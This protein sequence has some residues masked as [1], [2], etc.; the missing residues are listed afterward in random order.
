[1]TWKKRYRLDRKE[2]ARLVDFFEKMVPSLSTYAE[3]RGTSAQQLVTSVHNL[4]R[5]AEELGKDGL[6]QL[7]SAYAGILEGVLA[8]YDLSHSTPIIHGLPKR[9]GYH[10]LANI[11]VHTVSS[12]CV[13]K[14]LE[15]L[16]DYC[17][18]IKVDEESCA[19]PTMQVLPYFAATILKP[20][21]NEWTPETLGHALNYLNKK[22]ELWGCVPTDNYVVFKDVFGEPRYEPTEEGITGLISEE[23]TPDSFAHTLTR[24]F[25]IIDI[26]TTVREGVGAVKLR[27][28]P[29]IAAPI[30]DVNIRFRLG[31]SDKGIAYLAHAADF[32]KG[33]RKV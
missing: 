24:R 17:S 6:E 18:V 22:R 1:M 30:R 2:E 15:I 20:V 14:R 26:P 32:L 27:Y 33:V 28:Q 19:A 12:F 7:T 21:R 16:K 23:A 8:N 13:G 4:Y 29:R 11:V 9:D 25:G 3:V 10:E 5:N 31:L